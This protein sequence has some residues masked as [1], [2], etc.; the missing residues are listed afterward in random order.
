MNIHCIFAY[1]HN[2][3]IDVLI[4]VYICN[5]YMLKFFTNCAIVAFFG[6]MLCHWNYESFASIKYVFK[7]KFAK[8]KISPKT[9]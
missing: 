6:F 8:T 1:T 9:L 3:T 2:H 5:M 4:Y 7:K